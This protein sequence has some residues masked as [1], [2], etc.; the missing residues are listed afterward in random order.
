MTRKFCYNKHMDTKTKLSTMW[1]VVMLNMILADVLSAFLAI[2]D[3]S[4]LSIPGDAKQMMAVSAVVINLPILMIYFSR[5]LPYKP[6]RIANILTS[7]LTTLFIVGGGSLL[8]HYLIIALIEIVF[9]AA[10]LVT[11]VRWK[12]SNA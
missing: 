8:P 4:L 5:T 11:A 9:L 3:P 2:Q 6:N 10:I 7:I 12:R 1:L